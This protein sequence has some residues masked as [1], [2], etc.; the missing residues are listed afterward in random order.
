MSVLGLIMSSTPYLRSAMVWFPLWGWTFRL[1][2]RFNLHMIYIHRPQLLSKIFNI[3]TTHTALYRGLSKYLTAQDTRGTPT[4]TKYNRTLTMLGKLLSLQPQS[5]IPVIE[6]FFLA[7][8]SSKLIQK[9]RYSSE[10]VTK[11]FSIFFPKTKRNKTVLL[12]FVQSVF[13]AIS[14]AQV[15]LFF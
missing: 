10:L 13:M 7:L 11:I 2:L 3:L 4:L 14:Y 12:Q 5:T 6:D 1:L 15:H 8:V 9:T